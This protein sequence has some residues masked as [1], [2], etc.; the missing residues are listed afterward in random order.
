MVSRLSRK[1]F[2]ISSMSFLTST[3]YHVNAED[4]FSPSSFVITLLTL[5]T[6]RNWQQATTDWYCLIRIANNIMVEM[7]I[8]YREANFQWCLLSS[9]SK[10][11]LTVKRSRQQSFWELRM[12]RLHGL[13]VKTPLASYLINY[14]KLLQRKV[15]SVVRRISN[16]SLHL[17]CDVTGSSWA[18]ATTQDL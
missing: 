11:P 4:I 2:Y 18:P 7:A 3:Y 8:N 14:F 13:K 17:V 12:I 10:R 5:S 15:E 9:L 1:P 16:A 6:Y